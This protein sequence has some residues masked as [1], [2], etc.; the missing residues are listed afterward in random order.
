MADT[1]TFSCY[2][3]RN[4]LPIY[5]NHTTLADLCDHV[6]KYMREIDEQFYE[7]TLKEGLPPFITFVQKS[8]KLVFARDFVFNK[9]PLVWDCVLAMNC[10]QLERTDF[11]SFMGFLLAQLYY[12]RNL[13]M[14]SLQLPTF[15]NVFLEQNL[16]FP[17]KYDIE[18]FLKTA[19]KNYFN[20]LDQENKT[21]FDESPTKKSLKQLPLEPDFK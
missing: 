2:L 7:K 4:L 21:D 16:M 3:I 12:W 20:Y 13:N 18:G 19:V 17:N 14:D 11:F 1:Y 9:I 6:E 5:L 8:I 10:L 15:M